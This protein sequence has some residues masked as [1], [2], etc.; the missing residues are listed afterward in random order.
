MKEQQYHQKLAAICEKDSRYAVDAYL[1]VADAVAYTT[2]Q[3]TAAE[4]G[5]GRHI[6]GQELL[7][8][9]RQYA[10]QQFGPLSL[11]VLQDWGV[12]TTADFGNIVFTM[13]E[14]GL[15]GASD[16]DS[17][18]D[19]RDGY[20]FRKVFLQPFI[21]PEHEEPHLPHIP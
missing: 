15:L 7:E 12:K 16:N 18:D 9:I 1:F 2:K 6:S 8:G 17:P 19:F 14:N 10:L 11:D 5:R 20:D 4:S 3:L 13:V 21:A